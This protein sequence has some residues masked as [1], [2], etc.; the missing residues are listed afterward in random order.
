[1]CEF[2]EIESSDKEYKHKVLVWPNITYSEN[3]EKDSYVI[4]LSNVIKALKSVHDDIF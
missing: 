1:M 4:V 2:F 3:L